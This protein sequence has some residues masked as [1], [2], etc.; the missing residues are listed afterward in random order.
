MPSATTSLLQ[1]DLGQIWCFAEVW[2]VVLRA[3]KGR[4]DEVGLE[5]GYSD[6]QRT[7]QL[8]L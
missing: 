6:E 2:S 4:L 3:D 5:N 7:W 1:H 8:N